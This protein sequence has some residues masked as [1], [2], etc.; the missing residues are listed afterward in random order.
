MCAYL[1]RCN[2]LALMDWS[3]WNAFESKVYFCWAV[4]DANSACCSDAA[5]FCL[6]NS[7]SP[8]SLTRSSLF[9]SSACFSSST[10]SMNSWKQA[11][12]KVHKDFFFSTSVFL[13]LCTHNNNNNKQGWCGIFF[14]L[15]QQWVWRIFLCSK[16]RLTM[17]MMHL[18]P[19]LLKQAHLQK[20]YEHRWTAQMG[21]W[22]YSITVGDRLLKRGRKLC[23]NLVW[24]WTSLSRLS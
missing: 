17:W 9:F 10:S 6:T 1:H 12:P 15:Q 8:S 5:S 11:C 23:R 2:K 22:Y 14:R 18:E 19:T 16:L 13:T 24:T 21:S 7:V 20:D 4:A 3:R